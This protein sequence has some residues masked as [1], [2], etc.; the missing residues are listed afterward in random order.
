MTENI[1]EHTAGMPSRSGLEVVKE[2][3]QVSLNAFPDLHLKIDD[4]IAA[5][6]KVVSRWTMAGTH[7]NELLGIPPTGKRV[8]QTG[9]TIYRLANARIAE[10]WFF[11][12]SM[13]LMQQLGVIP[14]PD[15]A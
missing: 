4:E 6:D 13:G 1:V 11:P 8:R 3:L 10:L 9:V 2:G 12:D 7:Q 15:A 14:T 5:G